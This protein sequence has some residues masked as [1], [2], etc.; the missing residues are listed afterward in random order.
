MCLTVASVFGFYPLLALSFH[1]LGGSVVHV[2]LAFPNQLLCVLHYRLEVIR[3]VRELIG[4]DV[5][6]RNVFQDHLQ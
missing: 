1:L 5:Q 6:H 2:G 4:L 3:R